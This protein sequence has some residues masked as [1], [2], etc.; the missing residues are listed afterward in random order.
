MVYTVI[1][2]AFSVGLIYLGIAGKENFKSSNHTGPYYYVGSFIVAP[3]FAVTGILSAVVTV[4]PYIKRKTYRNDLDI[5]VVGYLLC[6]L[7]GFGGCIAGFV[8]VIRFGIQNCNTIDQRSENCSY[9]ETIDVNYTIAVISLVLILLLFLSAGCASTF[10]A[11]I[12]LTEEADSDASSINSSIRRRRRREIEDRE[13]ELR[14]LNAHRR[15]REN[16]LTRELKVFNSKCDLWIPESLLSK[17]I[18][19]LMVSSNLFQ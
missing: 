5:C 12:R 4:T 8:F 14:E 1:V 9:N 10:F 18:Q 11:S 6:N 15:E 13:A 19:I 7:L 3:V 2:L 16:Q 17:L